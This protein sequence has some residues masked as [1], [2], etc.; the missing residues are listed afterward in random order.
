MFIPKGYKL[1][2][3]FSENMELFL[4]TYRYRDSSC[5]YI[6]R[7]VVGPNEE[8]IRNY[9]LSDKKAIFIMGFDTS[10]SIILAG[11]DMHGLYWKEVIMNDKICIGYSHVDEYKLQDYESAL[12]TYVVK[13]NSCV[14]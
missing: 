8:N 1:K 9:N 11:I 3:T 12:K 13:L 6:G 2:R 14:E 10:S 7:Y 5:M 4:Y